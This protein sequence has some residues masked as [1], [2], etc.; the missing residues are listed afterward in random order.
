[1]ALLF[2]LLASV[3]TVIR[4]IRMVSRRWVWRVIFPMLT[5]IFLL[6][7]FLF[8]WSQ[9]W[10]RC[11]LWRVWRWWFWVQVIW[12][13]PFLYFEISVDRVCWLSVNGVTKSGC[14][15]SGIISVW[16]F[17]H[18]KTFLVSSP[19]LLIWLL[20]AF[21][22]LTLSIP[23]LDT[24]QSPFKLPPPPVLFKIYD[25]VEGE[26][27]E[28]GLPVVLTDEISKS[29][30]FELSLKTELANLIHLLGSRS[31]MTSPG[32]CLTLILSV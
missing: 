23:W 5:T 6:I 7:V 14:Q 15:I 31:V 30:N 12:F 8:L 20:Y 27:K 10:R 4:R 16:I 19:D 32:R 13:V 1:M 21:V 18:S 29:M 2:E 28:F 9:V 11:L 24:I 22:L 26:K 25:L 17:S 3:L